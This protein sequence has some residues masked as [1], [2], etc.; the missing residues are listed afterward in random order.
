MFTSLSESIIGRATE[1]G[2]I[3]LKFHQLRDFAEDKHKTVDDTPYGGGPGMVLKVDVVDRALTH[4]KEGIKERSGTMPK[5]ILLTP[6]GQPFSQRKA[7]QLS[8]HEDIVLI[9]GHYEGYDERIREYLVDEEISLGDYVLSGGEIAAMAVIDATA[10]LVPGVLGKEES[11]SE[12]SFSLQDDH[13]HQLLEYPVYTRPENYKGWTV[14]EI[15][16][17]GHHEEIKKWR[18][19][20]AVERTKEKRPD[21]LVSN[22]K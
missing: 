14:P 7:E 16:K 20:Q 3:G 4:I 8:G 9:C 15:L 5:V 22:K 6:Q 11:S 1:R 13:G 19:R 2:V 18:Y 21:L 12:E 10:R 17:S